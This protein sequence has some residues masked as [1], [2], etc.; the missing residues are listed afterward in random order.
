MASLAL[1]ASLVVL[2]TIL[3]GPF[4]YLLSRLNSS[5]FIIYPLSILCIIQGLW[6][7][8]IG[9]PIWYLGLVLIYFAYLSVNRVRTLNLRKVAEESIDNR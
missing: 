2:S 8:S 5:K 7:C 6:F 1:A 9:I 4:T 3:I